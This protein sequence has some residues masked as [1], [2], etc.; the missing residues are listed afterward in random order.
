MQVMSPGSTAGSDDVLFALGSIEA[1][2]A[3][4]S[5]PYHAELAALNKDKIGGNWKMMENG[6]RSGLFV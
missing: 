5:E 4:P 1:S 2:Q 3:S 6:T